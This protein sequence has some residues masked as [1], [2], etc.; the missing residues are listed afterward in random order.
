MP[1]KL[2]PLPLRQSNDGKWEVESSPGNWIKCE[3]K[4]DAKILSKAPIIL[5]ESYETFLPN[6]KVA[7]KLKSMTEKMKQYN[8]SGYRFFRQRAKHAQDK[9]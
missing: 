6:K 7:A 9:R 5:Q 4:A 8:M 2:K 1:K 3:N